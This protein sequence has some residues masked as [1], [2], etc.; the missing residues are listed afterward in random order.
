MAMKV[1]SDNTVASAADANEYFVNTKYAVKPSNTTRTGT[2]VSD[3]PDLVLNVGTNR[4][5]QLELIAPFTGASGAGGLKF[6]FSGP[7]GAQLFGYWQLTTAQGSSFGPVQG[8][9]YDGGVSQN[10]GT[11]QNI[12]ALTGVTLADTLAVRG[13]LQTGGTAGNFT[14][15]WSLNSASGNVTALAGSAMFLRRVS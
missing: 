1:F 14:F 8:G 2:S 5:F 3:D 13:W 10:L 9:T 12:S 11:T 7:A 6:A 15:R 4:T